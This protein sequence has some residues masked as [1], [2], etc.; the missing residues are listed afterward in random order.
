MIFCAILT[1]ATAQ[2]RRDHVVEIQ[3]LGKSVRLSNGRVSAVFRKTD[4]RCSDL[5][6]T[7]EENLLSKRGSLYLD[8]DSGGEHHTFTGNYE[9][10]NHTPEQ[11]HIRFAGRM[12]EF[13]AELNYVMQAGRS[14]FYSY[15][16]MRHGEKDRATYLE[17]LRMVLRCD[18]ET[19]IYAFSSKDKIGRMIDPALLAHTPS[20]IDATH[21]LPKKSGY[22]EPTGLTED[23]FP[24]YTKYDWA[25]Y[26]ESHKAHGL[27]GKSVGL[28][29]LG[30]SEEFTNGG[31]TR[32]EL[33]VHGTPTTPLMIKTYHSAHF[34]GDDSKIHLPAN[35]KWEKIYGPFF[36]YI[37]SGTNPMEMWRDALL[38][39]DQERAEWP[40]SWMKESSYP[41][42][43]G[44]VTG[45]WMIDGKAAANATFV[46]AQPGSDW[47]AQGADYL[48]WTRGD[49]NGTFT[50]PK[51]RPGTYSLYAFSPGTSG[52]MR[53]SDVSVKG[54][55][56]TSLGQFSWTPP[57]L[58]EI[59]WQ[60][61]TPDRS[62]AEFR[63]GDRMRQ[64]GLWWRYLSEMGTKDLN[65]DVDASSPSNWYYA[66]CVLPMDDRTYFSPKWNVSFKLTSIPGPTAALVID[67]VGT[68]NGG[69]V[70]PRLNVSLNGKTLTTLT[71]P[72]HDSSINRSV[73]K[74]SRYGL[75]RFEFP[76]SKLQRG[77]NVLT[78]QLRGRSPWTRETKP[79]AIGSGVIYDSIRLEAGTK[80]EE[81]I[82]REP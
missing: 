1:S 16:V 24:T 8:S 66:Q 58:S 32:A 78:F 51:V 38:K 67:T 80:I 71:L 37:N 7:G 54:G 42:E 73:T 82:S 69:D 60:I 4:G 45:R 10:V 17:Q 31:P 3:D 35:R 59:L 21:K 46:L 44:S 30:G 65:Y 12:G 56:T 28:W 39:A 27:A 29:M 33:M 72:P 41:I 18:P 74:S 79:A 55:H 14:G 25:D 5:R 34:V 40:Y 81:R 22:V 9:M 43:R 70:P 19:F 52:E 68:T 50:I 62:S 36:V 48:F 47:Q 15:L 64:Y 75:V 53:L 20:V 6:I 2:S 76:S 11:A 13:T 61:G 49:D 26:Q 77:T 23:G 63:F 57:R